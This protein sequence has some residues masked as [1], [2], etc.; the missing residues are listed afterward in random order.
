M[1]HGIRLMVVVWTWIGFL[2]AA[3]LLGAH[4]LLVESDPTRISFATILV[5]TVASVRLVLASVTNPARPVPLENYWFVSDVCLTLG[6]AGTVLGF[7]FMFDGMD[8]IHV[9]ATD[10]EATK[11]IIASL[12]EGLGTAL[13]TT[14]VGITCS[15]YLKV[16]CRVVEDRNDDL[17]SVP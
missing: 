16:L 14:L 5:A 2:V 13:Y 6:L 9:D 10:V 15:T 1:R 4:H 12:A 7:I 8:L 3:S 11:R 17:E